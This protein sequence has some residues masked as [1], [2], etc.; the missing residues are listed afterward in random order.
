MQYSAQSNNASIN[1]GFFSTMGAGTSRAP[2]RSARRDDDDV[3][4][5]R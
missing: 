1:D 4:A 2:G 5:R 3:T